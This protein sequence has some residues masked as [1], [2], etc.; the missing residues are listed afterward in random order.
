MGLCRWLCWEA[1]P[2]SVRSAVPLE[3]F[4]ALVMRVAAEGAARSEKARASPREE[5]IRF[6]NSSALAALCAGG[7]PAHG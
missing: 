4:P 2:A 7:K 3:F 5:R 1:R 6:L